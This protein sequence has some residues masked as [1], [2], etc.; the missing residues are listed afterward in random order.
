MPLPG[1]AH[2]EH[3]VLGRGDRVAGRDHALGAA[4]ARHQ[5]DGAQAVAAGVEE[6][7]LVAPAQARRRGASATASQSAPAPFAAGV[8]AVQEHV[9]P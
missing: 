9:R 5:H 6:A 2:A 4:R 7:G 3:D 8:L 1:R